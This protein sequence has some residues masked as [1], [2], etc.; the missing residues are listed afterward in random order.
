MG[1][2]NLQ[3]SQYNAGQKKRNSDPLIFVS[4]LEE[5]DQLWRWLTVFKVEPPPSGGSRE[6]LNSE[7]RFF[8][9][10]LYSAQK[11]HLLCRCIKIWFLGG[12]PTDYDMLHR[13]GSGG[14]LSANTPTL[15][16][17]LCAG[18]CIWLELCIHWGHFDIFRC[19]M[20]PIF[21]KMS[22]SIPGMNIMKRFG[23]DPISGSSE[24]CIKEV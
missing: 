24:L 14:H 6:I 1:P 23:K 11:F 16:S 20:L 15:L 18:V 7:L 22:I 9:P 3:G 4:S 10:A 8:W 5:V 12:L 21:H 19:P 17:S 13:I 2:E